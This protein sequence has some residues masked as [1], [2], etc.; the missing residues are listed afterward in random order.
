MAER[1]GARLP[2]RRVS[3]TLEYLDSW[4]EPYHYDELTSERLSGPGDPDRTPPAKVRTQ[5]FDL[6]SHA[7]RPAEESAEW[8]TNYR[9]E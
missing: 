3:R 8:I 2:R 6:W 4:G 5:T 1:R 9:N 7:G